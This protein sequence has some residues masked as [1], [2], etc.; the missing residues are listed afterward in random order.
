MS[1]VLTLGIKLIENHVSVRLMTGR[2]SYDFIV[3]G[4]P[5]E[6]TNGIGPNCDV[7]ISCRAIFKLYGKCKIMRLGGVFLAMQDRFVDV[8][9]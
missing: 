1:Y 5:F 3:L 4:H 2:K 6:K 7:G 8:Y 9:E